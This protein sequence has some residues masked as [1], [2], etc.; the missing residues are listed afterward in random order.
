MRQLHGEQFD[1]EELLQFKKKIQASCLKHFVGIIPDFL[2]YE[3]ITTLDQL[4]CENFR[5]KCEDKSKS[6]KELFDEG[7]IIW[8]S[9][10]FQNY[11]QGIIKVHH[12]SKTTSVGSFK[13][14]TPEN[15][16]CRLPK[17]LHSDDPANHFLRC[18]ERI[19]DR[20]YQPSLE[21]ILSLRAPTTGIL[22]YIYENT[23]RGTH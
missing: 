12:V 6:D 23:N 18:F 2:K 21:D 14:N 17:K 13:S 4:K 20:G 3:T 15:A 1:D 16:P 8:R 22:E 19:A 5:K 7:I 11:I 9:F 10:S